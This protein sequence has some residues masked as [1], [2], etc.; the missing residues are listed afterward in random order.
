[1]DAVQFVFPV[2]KVTTARLARR[3]PV[4]QEH[5]LMSEPQPVRT[6]QQGCSARTVENNPAHR[7]RT[8]AETPHV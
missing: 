5:F 1:M 8:L 4:Q 3:E 2:Q 7:E 6:A